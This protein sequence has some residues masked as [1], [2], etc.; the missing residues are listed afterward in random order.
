MLDI[1][2]L[3]KD[4]ESYDQLKELCV[5][6][7]IRKNYEAGIHK[8]SSSDTPDTAAIYMFDYDDDTERLS[9]AVRRINSGSYVIVLVDGMDKLKKAVTPGISPSGI[10]IKPWN[11]DDIYTVL[12]EVYNDY[13]HSGVSEQYGMF[14]FKLKAKEYSIPYERILFFE[15]RNKKIIV[16]T[17]T[18]EL[19]YYSTLDSVLSAAPDCFMK[20]HKSFVVNVAR[21]SA[22]DYGAMTVEFDDGSAAFMSRTYKAELKERLSMRSE[23]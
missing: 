22:A 15:S 18:Q 1:F 9:K 3:E 19:E 12:D 5:R 20:I 21:I 6:Y 7:L 16:R 8:Y 4:K 14:S 23:H 11:K 2:I 17:E 13:F 10:A